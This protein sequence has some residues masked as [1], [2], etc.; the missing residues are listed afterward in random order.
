MQLRHLVKL[1][2]G[3]RNHGGELEQLLLRESTSST[4]S[5]GVTLVAQLAPRRKVLN[6]P[7]RPLR[8]Y[9]KAIC[10][11]IPSNIGSQIFRRGRV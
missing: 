7:S 11:V 10:F 9:E 1:P 3:D 2:R 5:P 6:W 4:K 8:G